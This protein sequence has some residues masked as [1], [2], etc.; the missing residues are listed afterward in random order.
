VLVHVL[1]VVE[2][3]VE[4]VVVEPATT[5]EQP[6][7]K[8]PVVEVVEVGEALVLDVVCVA[9]GLDVV[10]VALVLD[11]PAGAAV[12]V[13]VVVVVAPAGAAVVVRV[14]VAVVVAVVDVVEV[15]GGPVRFGKDAG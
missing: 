10:C 11:V 8:V 2:D 3:V 13:R 15:L 7:V 14:V 12:V 1:G 9:L 5:V 6:L 4:A